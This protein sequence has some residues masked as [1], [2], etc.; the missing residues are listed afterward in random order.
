MYLLKGLRYINILKIA[1]LMIFIS[2][3][4]PPIAEANNELDN[5]WEIPLHHIQYAEESSGDSKNTN[6]VFIPM[7]GTWSTDFHQQNNKNGFTWLRFS[8]SELNQSSNLGDNLHL[9]VYP[10][11]Y[12]FEVYQNDLLIYQFGEIANNDL[13]ERVPRFEKI[14]LENSTD[15]VYIRFKGNSPYLYTI[16]TDAGLVNYIM[17]ADAINIISIIGFFFTGLFALL[18]YLYN[19][20]IRIMLYYGLFIIVHFSIWPTAN[21]LLSKQLFIP[22][23]TVVQFYL[24]V[25][26]QIIAFSLLLFLFREIVYPKY[27]K[28]VLWSNCLFIGTGISGVLITT[29]F[30]NFVAILFPLLGILIGINML[31]ILIVSILSIKQQKNSELVVFSIGLV[32]FIIL[33]IVIN[34]ASATSMTGIVTVVKM[35]R[36]FTI[37]LPGVLIIMNRYRQ[38]DKKAQEYAASLKELTHRLEVDNLTLENRVQE[39]TKELERAHHQLVESMQE[40]AIAAVEIAAL[41]ERNRIAQEIHD[42][43]GHTLTT[44]I[45]QIEAGKRLLEKQPSQAKERMETSQLLIRKGLDEIRS[46]VRLLK[47]AEWNYNLT[48]ALKQIMKESTE[49][50]GVNFECHIDVPPELTIIQKNFIYMA[51]KEGITNGIKHGDC[52]SFYFTLREEHDQIV[53]QLKNDGKP[54]S[55]DQLGFG[56][57][58]MKKRVESLKGTLTIRSEAEWNYVIEIKFPM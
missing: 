1:S 44:T 22:M 13:R 35:I 46:S 49:Y 5:Y 45:V 21:Y 52:K 2:I 29:F 41:E 58:T 16:G 37:V 15:D 34:I 42:I 26:G 47:D 11:P 12:Y 23:P 40:G 25:L 43:V 17:K 33:E 10:S 32:L 4:F 36:P 50:G 51:L 18:L 27:R 7:H 8:P 57:S 54:F 6:L 3:I 20:K 9:L 19:R 38:A 14:P 53:F 28:W 39:R 55:Q 24:T 30:T 56:L 31:M 48:N